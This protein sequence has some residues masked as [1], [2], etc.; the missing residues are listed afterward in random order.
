MDQIA[1]VHTA[2]LRFA[3]L[4]CVGEV[5]IC[6]ER[7][8]EIRVAKVRIDETRVDE[9]RPAKIRAAEVNNFVGVLVPPTFS[10]FHSFL[11]DF[12]LCCI[13]HASG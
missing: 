9:V 7:A 1:S 13:R 11:E 3:R 4:R 12:Q 6:E 10:S 8:A 2:L 5:R